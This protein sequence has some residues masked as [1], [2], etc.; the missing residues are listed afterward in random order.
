[1]ANF[2]R[3]EAKVVCKIPLSRRFVEDSLVWLHNKSG[4]TLF[5]QG[6]T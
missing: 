4:F 6:I 5:D 1:M 2:N 3:D